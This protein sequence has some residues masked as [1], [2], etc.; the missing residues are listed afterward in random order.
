M[1]MSYA[2]AIAPVLL[3]IDFDVAGAGFG[4]A[5]RRIS[6]PTTSSPY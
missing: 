1:M 5:D 2:L 4:T 3:K 6:P